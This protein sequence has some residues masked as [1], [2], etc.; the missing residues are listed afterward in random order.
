[1]RVSR[2]GAGGL[3]EDWTRLRLRLGAEGAR[4]GARE[5]A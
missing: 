2:V 4:N 5:R 3:Q 1:M